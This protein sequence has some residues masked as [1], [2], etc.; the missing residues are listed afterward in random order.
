MLFACTCRVK[1]TAPGTVAFL[2][3][4][5]TCWA[6]WSAPV[7]YC[8]SLHTCSKFSALGTHQAA[9][10]MCSYVMGYIVY[11]HIFVQDLGPTYGLFLIRT[12][13]PSL[14]H[15]LGHSASGDQ[16]GDLNVMLFSSGFSACAC[17]HSCL[18]LLPRRCTF[19][20]PM[21]CWNSW[22]SRL[23]NSLTSRFL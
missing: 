12:V 4:S 2:N 5:S 3:I 13:S 6:N 19:V 17:S 11:V 15:S 16:T 23:Q 20:K 21:A 8:T 1:Q 9:V 7:V 22:E 14:D 18:C 10:H